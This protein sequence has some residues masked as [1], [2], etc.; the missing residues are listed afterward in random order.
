MGR[1]L[2]YQ[3]GLNCVFIHETAKGASFKWQGDLFLTLWMVFAEV[4]SLMVAQVF[5]ALCFI[6]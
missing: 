6:F 2:Y 5:D 3:N 4:N 1:S